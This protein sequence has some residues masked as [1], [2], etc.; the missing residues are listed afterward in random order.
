MCEH[1]NGS[2]RVAPTHLPPIPV[3]TH[4][5]GSHTLSSTLNGHG[6]NRSDPQRSARNHHGNGGGTHALT[7]LRGE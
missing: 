6:L 1:M 3:Q 2:G 5:R 4:Q 7:A